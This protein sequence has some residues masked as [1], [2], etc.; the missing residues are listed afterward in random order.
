MENTEKIVFNNVLNNIQLGFVLGYKD[1]REEYIFYQ[2]NGKILFFMF[3]IL[4]VLFV[5]LFGNGQLI[6][7]G[8]E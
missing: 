5:I 7:G 1:E 3:L 8:Q 2:A 6:E 4:F